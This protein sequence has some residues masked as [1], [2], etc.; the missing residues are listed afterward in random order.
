[1][2]EEADH[3]EN[4]D[5]KITLL[6]SC[7]K[8]VT[9]SLGV[10]CRILNTSCIDLFLKLKFDFS[11]AHS[12]LFSKF[13]RNNRRGRGKAIMSPTQVRSHKGIRAPSSFQSFV[14]A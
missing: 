10:T 2:E 3:E 14:F 11:V 5:S 9:T 4:P 6:C 12:A 13:A 7:L 8:T 1:M